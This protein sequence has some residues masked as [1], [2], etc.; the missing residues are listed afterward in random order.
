MREN[1]KLDELRDELN[2]MINNNL[3]P[4]EILKLSQELD[5]YIVEEMKKDY[6]ILDE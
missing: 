5:V 6:E 2:E 3:D 4:K 1:S